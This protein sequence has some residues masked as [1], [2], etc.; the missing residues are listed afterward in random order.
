MELVGQ[1]EF[2]DHHHF[3]V[4]DA[5]RIEE[6]AG[7]AGAEALVCTQK[8]IYNLQD[9]CFRNLPLY[10]CQISLRVAEPE[11]FWD[12]ILAVVERKRQEGAP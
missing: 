7:A 2:P 4:A 6:D 3:T 8:D 9:V 5:K 10:S 11:R 1:R 12:T